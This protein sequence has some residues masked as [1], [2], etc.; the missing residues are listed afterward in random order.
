MLSILAAILIIFS[1]TYGV[2]ATSLGHA[3]ATGE[4]RGRA[5]LLVYLATLVIL[6]VPCYYIADRITLAPTVSPLLWGW[7]GSHFGASYTVA[8]V[9]TVVLMVAV[10]G[11]RILA[12]PVV[13]PPPFQGEWPKVGPS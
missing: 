12:D 11:G 10:Y 13:E 8:A 1:K 3:F 4:F 9:L 5:A 6:V 7:G 2:I